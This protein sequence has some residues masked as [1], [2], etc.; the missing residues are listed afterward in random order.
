MLKKFNRAMRYI[1]SYTNFKNALLLLLALCFLLSGCKKEVE[2]T[3]FDEGDMSTNVDELPPPA[4]SGVAE[5]K[6]LSIMVGQNPAT[7]HPLAVLDENTANLLSLITEPAIQISADGKFSAGVIQS[8]DVSEDGLT[9]TFHIRKNVLFHRDYGSVTADDL[10]FALEKIKSSD[11][12]Q[13]EYAKYSSVLASY[14]KIDDLT[15]KVVATKKSRD[16]FYLMNFPVI[17]KSYYEQLGLD[18]KK[19]PIGTGPYFVESES[20][21]GFVLSCNAA[22]WQEEPVYDQII[23]KPVSDDELKIGSSALEQFQVIY[24]SLMTANS[25]S[26]AGKNEIHQV[27]TPTYDC[28]VPN[29]RNEFLAKREVREAISIALNRSELI[30]VALLGQGQAAEM[31]VNPNFWAYEGLESS[32][33]V[34]NAAEANRLL[35]NAGL[36]MDEEQGL[37]YVENADGSK[38]YVKFKLLY[39]ESTEYAYRKALCEKIA[40]QLKLVGIEIELVEADAQTYRSYLDSGNF[41]LA[42]CS[43]FTNANGDNAFLFSEYNYGKA[44]TQALGG[45]LDAFRAAITSEEIKST[46]SEYV[47][48]YL[49]EIPTIGLH[50][51]THAAILDANISAPSRLAYKNIYADIGQW[52]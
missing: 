4:G 22:W 24:T 29:Y 23:A 8:W 41:Q 51:R 48:A 50:Y 30:S 44:P 28:L 15:L 52:K 9:Y 6:T 11:A 47:R 21:E 26:A 35:E 46:F 16:I 40:E 5:K 1:E 10:I 12:T 39:T 45:K 27:V 31:P 25:Y 43:F 20:A 34:Y 32:A 19:P 13:C 7:L 33:G 36:A 14:E 3:P 2:V 42:L 17:P 37:R 49:E 18:T 38:R